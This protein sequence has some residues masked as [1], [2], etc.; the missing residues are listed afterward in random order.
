MSP[1]LVLNLKTVSRIRGLFVDSSSQIIGVKLCTQ[2]ISLDEFK[3]MFLSTL[4]LFCVDVYSHLPKCPYTSTKKNDSSI[5][6]LS[7]STSLFIESY[8]TAYRN[9]G[10]SG[11]RNTCKDIFGD[12]PIFPI[13]LDNDNTV[14]VAV[15]AISFEEE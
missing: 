4:R 1:E 11:S 2:D 8:Q 15:K 12:V 7:R 10:N 5:I 13:T 9:L 3:K 6:L 14:V